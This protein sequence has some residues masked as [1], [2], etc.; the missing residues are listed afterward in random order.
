ME[1]AGGALRGTL[2]GLAVAGLM[3][4]MLM[5]L[6][7]PAFARAGRSIQTDGDRTLRKVETPSGKVNETAHR[8][9]SGPQGGD[10]GGAAH[11][12]YNISRDLDLKRAETPSE[13][14]NVSLHN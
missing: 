4:A 10:G 7:S 8:L 9:P 6:T 2:S 1:Q 11:S 13:N 12:V 5:A 3:T 14:I